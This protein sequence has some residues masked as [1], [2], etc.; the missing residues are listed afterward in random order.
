MAGLILITTAVSFTA[1]APD[2]FEYFLYIPE[3]AVNKDISETYCR[4]QYE[5]ELV[6][7]HSDNERQT[8]A[9]MIRSI[10]N[11]KGFS[12]TT[13]FWTGL[14]RIGLISPDTDANW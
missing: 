3:S 1:A 6:S 2:Q 10:I 12:I 7:L 8:V 4:V 13:R 5:G 9:S 11:A 14:G